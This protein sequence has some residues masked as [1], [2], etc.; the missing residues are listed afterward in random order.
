MRPHVIAFAIDQRQDFFVSLAYARMLGQRRD[1]RPFETVALLLPGM[2]FEEF[3]PYLGGFDRVEVLSGYH[4]PNRLRAVPGVLRL[5]LRYRRQVRALDLRRT[6]VVV[7]YSF[8]AIVLNAIARSATE[9]PFLVRVRR[10]DHGQER[11]LTR[12]RPVVSA[13][14]NLW[15]RAFGYSRLRYR[16]LPSSNRHGAGTYLHDPY[17]AEFCLTMTPPTDSSAS[18]LPWPFPVL[19]QGYETAAGE[20]VRPTVVVLGERYPLVEGDDLDRFRVRLDE[21]LRFVRESHPE[22]RLVFKP[23]SELSEIGQNLEGYE[24]GR[25]DVVLESLLLEDPTIE[26]VLSFKSSGSVIATLYGA[27]GYLLYP[28]CDFPDDFRSHLDEYFADA[29][30]S[31]VNV[32]RLEDVVGEAP[33]ALLPGPEEIVRRS[34]PLLDTL[35]QGR[36]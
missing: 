12:R 13:Y 20:D 25:S 24:R 19:R 8:R 26:K 21:V 4:P 30:E 28:L 2:V 16:W 9:K 33:R 15:N 7:G 17:D 18:A 23:R 3:R 35:V 34:A 11:L 36:A 10:C 32:T 31:V 29:Q 22:H 14:W 27:A 6:D 5:A 1:E